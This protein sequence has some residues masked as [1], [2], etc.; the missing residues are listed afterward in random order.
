MIDPAGREGYTIQCFPFDLY[1]A[2]GNLGELIVTSKS[3]P[4]DIGWGFEESR[5]DYLYIRRSADNSKVLT[6][7]SFSENSP[8]LVADK[9]GGLFFHTRRREVE[10]LAYT[11]A[12]NDKRAIPW[13]ISY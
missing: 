3:M 13:T 11:G 2:I 7:S 10:P 4:F 9:S 1:L 8:V 5:P 12:T 6:L